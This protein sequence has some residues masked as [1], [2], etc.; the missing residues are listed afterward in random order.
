MVIFIYISKNLLFKDEQ[1]SSVKLTNNVIYL[2][3]LFLKV[4]YITLQIKPWPD[5]ILAGYYSIILT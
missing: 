4:I 5:L 3:I 1:H 2:V